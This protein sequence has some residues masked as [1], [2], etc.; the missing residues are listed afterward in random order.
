MNQE[1][2]LLSS[3]IHTIVDKILRSVY[4][5]YGFLVWTAGFAIYDLIVLDGTLRLVIGGLF[6]FIA[7]AQFVMAT[8]VE[9]WRRISDN[10]RKMSEDWKELYE[11][12]ARMPR[13]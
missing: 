2:D 13:A 10:W 3:R 9:S 4:W 8:S 5:R 1:S 12:V 11:K 7:G 6:S